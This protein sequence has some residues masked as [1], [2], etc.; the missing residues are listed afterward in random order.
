[1][2]IPGRDQWVHLNNFTIAINHQHLLSFGPF[3]WVTQSR[4]AILRWVSPSSLC[5]TII[6]GCGMHQLI[7]KCSPS[8]TKLWKCN[9]VKITIIVNTFMQRNR[10]KGRHDTNLPK[11]RMSRMG[12]APWPN[13]LPHKGGGDLSRIPNSRWE[14]GQ[15]QNGNGLWSQKMWWLTYIMCLLYVIF[16]VLGT[17]KV[18]PNEEPKTIQTK[19]RSSATRKDHPSSAARIR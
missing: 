14:S 16:F 4:I 18:R 2:G 1:M 15:N 5:I 17:P 10:H 19:K 13:L 12:V 7:Q 11:E 3:W 8:T 9:E 6:H